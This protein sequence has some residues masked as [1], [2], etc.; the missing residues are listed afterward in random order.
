MTF[1]ENN[2]IHIP[3]QTVFID[4]C[5]L[6][7]PDFEI[8]SVSI[9]PNPSQDFVSINSEKPITEFQVY[10][11]LGR[12][13]YKST[14]SKY[15]EMLDISAYTNGIYFVRLEVDGQISTFQILKN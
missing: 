6:S 11:A 14:S 1:A 4:D 2:F 9:F 10:S 12:L 5:L 15:T 8:N 3:S 7:N 13:I